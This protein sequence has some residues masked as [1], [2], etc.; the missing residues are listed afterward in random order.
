MAVLAYLSVI[1]PNLYRVYY[2]FV[3]R[4]GGS[5][6]IDGLDQLAEWVSKWKQVNEQLHNAH[7]GLISEK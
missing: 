6:D 7:K 1:F 4:V 3:F 5:D 2:P